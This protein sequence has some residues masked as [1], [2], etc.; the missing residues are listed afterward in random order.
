ML[1]ARAHTIFHTKRRQTWKAMYCKIDPLSSVHGYFSMKNIKNPYYTYKGKG[2]SKP[3]KAL[4][5]LNF[6]SKTIRGY[7]N[8]WAKALLVFF[9]KNSKRY[10]RSFFFNQMGGFFRLIYSQWAVCGFVITGAQCKHTDTCAHAVATPRQTHWLAG[11][12]AGHMTLLG[13]VSWRSQ[14]RKNK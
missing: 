9:L 1:K 4:L 8:C 14:L 12:T 13:K 7:I 3:P 5:S 11:R 10:T 6:K 2:S